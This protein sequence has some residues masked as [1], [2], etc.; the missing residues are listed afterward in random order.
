MGHAPS[1]GG[2]FQQKL[3]GECGEYFTGNLGTSAEITFI[4]FLFYVFLG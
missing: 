3:G 4:I 1:V 2:E